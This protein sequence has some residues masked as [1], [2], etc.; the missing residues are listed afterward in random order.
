MFI[1]KCS[2]FDVRFW[3]YIPFKHKCSNYCY[4]GVRHVYL[5]LCQVGVGY[6]ELRRR[7]GGLYEGI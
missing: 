4:T 7:I 1:I 2:L 5:K 6:H 3:N